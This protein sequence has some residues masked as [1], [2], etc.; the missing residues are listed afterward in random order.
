MTPD[1]H[2]H[3]V[4]LPAN[5]VWRTYPGGATLDWLAGKENPGDSHFPEDWIA[6]IT[7]ARNA[8]REHLRE[9][10][11][12]VEVGGRSHELDGLIARDP[13]Y[14]LGSA[15]VARHG[16]SPM[17]LVKFL[18]PAIRLHVQAHPTREFARAHLG[19]ISGKTEAYHVLAV[20]ENVAQPHLYL[21]FQHPPAREEFRRMVEA[22]D[23]AAIERCFE[24][25]PLA[26]GD[27]II[28]P[29]GLPHAVGAG[30]FLVEIQEPSD[31]VVRLEFE[32]GGYVLPERARF[33]DRG[34]DFAL[35]LIDFAAHPLAEIDA[36]WRCRPQRRRELAPG[37]WQDTL[38]GPE[39]TPCFR[40]RRTHLE[41]P[42]AKREDE[43][44][45]AIVTEGACTIET[46][47]GRHRLGRFDKCLLPAGLGEV[48]ISPL[49]PT[50][51]IECYPPA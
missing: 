45:V 24:K 3:L 49:A 4:L 44:H 33:M 22:Q 42:V 21:G 32:R 37:S 7:T 12:T 43:F 16:A 11:S 36:R 41:S 8:G 31:L 13:E 30:V 51:I 28:V 6:S 40:V 34:I 29:G 15:H 48:L 18:D 50:E 9:G 27:T 14:F 38:I 35:S 25:V 26:P 39:H 46:A 2:G 1:L 17:L 20:R 19:A 23:V 5:R 47:R 10:V